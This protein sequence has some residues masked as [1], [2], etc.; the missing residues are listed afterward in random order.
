M[1][2]PPK[3]RQPPTTAPN[4][5]NGTN[6]T[7]PPTSFRAQHH[8]NTRAGTPP[9]PHG[10]AGPEADRN[11]VSEN[12]DENDPDADN[13]GAQNDVDAKETSSSGKRLEAKGLHNP[14]ATMAD[15]NWLEENFDD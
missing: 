7:S 15:P 13:S 3:H 9:R 4:S 12:W 10:N 14:T 6:N 8:P 2:R 11:F 5:S 1:G